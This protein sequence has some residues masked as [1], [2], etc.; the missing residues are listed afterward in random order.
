MRGKRSTESISHWKA[1]GPEEYR[2]QKRMKYKRRNQMTTLCGEPDET[3]MGFNLS[4]QQKLFGGESITKEGDE[5]RNE[6]NQ[7]PPWSLQPLGSLG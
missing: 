1:S 2:W 6:T 3:P 5:K 4:L 7:W